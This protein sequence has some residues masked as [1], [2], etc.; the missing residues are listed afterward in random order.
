MKELDKIDQNLLNLLQ[1]NARLT[2]K[3]LS[4]QL[5][6]SPTAVYERI[7]KLEREDYILN[8]VAMV[9]PQKVKKDFIAFA[10]LQLAKHSAENITDFEK[11]IKALPEVVACFHI[12]GS[13]DYLLKINLEDMK[14]FRKFMVE[15]LTE[16]PHISNTQSVFSIHEVFNYTALP[17]N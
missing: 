1:Q 8:Y 11:N 3:Q 17:V 9:N 2:T 5:N 10:M 7:K 14:A 15:K 13:Y 16:I 12:S 4:M 6:L